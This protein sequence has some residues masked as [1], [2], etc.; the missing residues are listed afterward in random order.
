MANVRP[1]L[2][3]SELLPLTPAV[4]NILLC[5][6]DGEKH[7]YAIMQE[8][9]LLTRG[10]VKM[11]PGTLY[12]SLDRMLDARLI[13]EAEGQRTSE[14]ARRRY[15]RLT[16][17]GK[18]VLSAEVNRLSEQLKVVRLKRLLPNQH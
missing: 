4:F 5:L 3:P 1:R 18:Q 11:G 17:F 2:D 12:G 16:S 15:Y 8:V 9:D 6:S 13:S 7:G 14:D 10:K